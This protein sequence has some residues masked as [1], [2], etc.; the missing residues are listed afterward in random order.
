MKKSNVTSDGEKVQATE[1]TREVEDEGDDSILDNSAYEEATPTNTRSK[2][3]IRIV[4]QGIGEKKL[5]RLMT[6][7]QI[8]NYSGI[9]KKDL[10]MDSL[11]SVGGSSR[12]RSDFDRDQLNHGTSEA[13]VRIRRTVIGEKK[14]K[15]A[16]GDK[17]DFNNNSSGF[18]ELQSSQQELNSKKLKTS[19]N[20]HM[21]STLTPIIVDKQI[22]ERRKMLYEES[23]RIKNSRINGP[24]EVSWAV[25]PLSV[26]NQ[27][28]HKRSKNDKVPI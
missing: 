24:D 8:S 12:S 19:G 20:P 23:K 1:V 28:S 17:S 7:T 27:S 10:S 11:K 5:R 21:S 16:Q 26:S 15:R 13:R 22:I 18:I 4:R 2:S 25:W 6:N 3:Q 14:L 9:E